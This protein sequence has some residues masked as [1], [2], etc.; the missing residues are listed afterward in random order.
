MD[1]GRQDRGR[2]RGR[3]GGRQMGGK[4]LMQSSLVGKPL[5]LLV[6]GVYGQRRS[7]GKKGDRKE[8][9]REGG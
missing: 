1:E 5:W 2:E 9:G 6:F 3:K 4:G 7:D 8:G